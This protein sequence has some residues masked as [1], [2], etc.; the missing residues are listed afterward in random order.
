MRAA[1]L[2]LM[3]LSFWLVA[4][5]AAGTPTVPADDLP[6]EFRRD[7]HILE[8]ERFQWRLA[9]RNEKAAE[10]LASQPDMNVVTEVWHT[11]L[12]K[13][14]HVL[15]IVFA[16]PYKVEGNGINLYIKADNDPGTG[17]RAAGIMEGVDYMF[18]F[19]FRGE[20][21]QARS[22]TH[23]DGEGKAA[24][25]G[26]ADVLRGDTLYLSVDMACQQL[27][28]ASVL[29]FRSSSYT[30]VEVDGKWQVG[31]R[32]GYGPVRFSGAPEPTTTPK[33]PPFTPLVNPELK[34]KGD[35][36]PGWQLK[37]RTSGSEARA[38]WDVEADALRIGRLHPSEALRQRI[39]VAPGHYL[40]RAL[41]RT[42]AFRMHLVAGS[43]KMPV[44]VSAEFRWVELP[45]LVQHVE[46]KGG[47]SLDVGF[48]YMGRTSSAPPAHLPVTLW[49]RRVELRRLGDTVLQRD[50]M[51]N[52]PAHP[53]HH[54]DLIEASPSRS[55]PGKVVFRDSFVGTELWLMTQGGQDDHSYVG[56]PD[57]NRDG[58]F[59]HIGYRRAPSGVLRTD[60]SA[61]YMNNKWHHL[62]WLFPWMERRLPPG[63]N[64]VEWV[65]DSRTDEAVTL[66]N[67]VNGGSCRIELP[68]RPGWRIVHYPGSSSYGARG[69]RIPAVD[70]E[71]MVWLAED[72]RSVAT[73]TAEGDAFRFYPIP[74]ISAAP[75]EDIVHDCIATAL[76]KPGDNWRDAV[77]GQDRRYFFF[78]LNQDNL[79]TH[80]TNPYQV[81]A[82]P[83][84]GKHRGPLRVVS[85]P[86]G[87]VTGIV[88]SVLGGRVK[89]KS[90]MWWDFAAGLPWSGDDARFLLEDGTLVHM[91]SLGG[92]GS[93]AFAGPTTVTLNG[94][95]SEENRFVGTYTRIDR[96]TWPHEYRRDRDFAVVGGL[97][98]PVLPLLMIDL[99]HK[100]MWTATLTNYYDYRSRYGNHLDK[101]SYRKPMF[102]PAPTFSPDFT[103]VSY[104]SSM[105]TGDVPERPLGDVYIA[106]VRYPAPPRSV[107]LGWR[108]T[109][110]WELPQHHAEI[111]GY[112][113]YRSDESGRGY[114]RAA[115]KLLTGTNHRLPADASGFYVLTSVEHSGLEGRVFS[116]EVQL[117]DAPLFRHFHELEHG[118][119]QAPMVPCFDPADASGGYAVALSDPEHVYHEALAQGLR[120]RVALPLRVPERRGLH[121]WA[122]VRGLSELERA[123]YTHGWPC[124][125]KD[126]PAGSMELRCAGQILGSFP[127]RG[128]R[129]HW[130]PLDAGAV[131]L[132]KRKAILEL[133]TSD[134]GVAVDVLC[135]TNDAEFRPTGHGASPVSLPSVPTG[136]EPAVFTL[137]DADIHQLPGASV[138]FTWISTPAPQGV[139]RYQVYR[140]RKPDFPAGA[141]HL[142][143]SPA[144]P[145]FYDCDLEPESTHF[146]RVRAMDAWGNLSGASDALGIRASVSPLRP[147]FRHEP[148]NGG[149]SPSGTSVAFDATESRA[150]GG[151]IN[152]WLW[153][154]GDG[155]V[156]EG[157]K[158]NHTYAE[159]GSHTVTLRI[160]T[161]LGQGAKLT[162]A[163]HVAAARIQRVRAAGGIWIEAEEKT[164][165]GGGKSRTFSG[166]VN[167]SGKI[168]TYWG[169]E[170]GHWLEWTI[171]V[172]KAGVYAIALRYAARAKATRDCRIDGESPG[173]DWN[174][175]V[176]PNTGGYSTTADNWSWRMLKDGNGEPLRHRLSAGKH[177][178]HLTA[179]VAG[180]AVDTIFC[181]PIDCAKELE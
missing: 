48:G 169:G 77:D 172:T 32:L 26:F 4:H 66:V 160:G 156:S 3:P 71:T 65:I 158:V 18:S 68:S 67:A 87:P 85:H 141:E 140:G 104:F 130:V 31:K 83:L 142:I 19:S 61:R 51:K 74:S 91:S 134:R 57:F 170:K 15:K 132:P 88:T 122:R 22:W 72:N 47:K 33:P 147:A 159:P 109:L 6:T 1:F 56:T 116:N 58:S 81:V 135:I 166:R 92:H 120:G 138:K 25:T 86:V 125:D 168:V 153:D 121:V 179:Q 70:H 115:G 29:E 82:V 165:E 129:W 69:P 103:K 36:V 60:G 152:T 43:M 171:P 94:L 154:F 117:G 112:R 75:E 161:D 110:S 7:S 144:E 40:L 123:T 98:E 149:L 11:P 62:V 139:A 8:K 37:V 24:P 167:A 16:Q 146:Y 9:G 173:P 131:L 21:P 44:P 181:I 90:G 148:R 108:R 176:F 175:L 41:A 164:G 126:T 64:P 73:S 124:K 100:T 42:D 97:D 49:A 118:Q 119:I 99:E 12:H 93:F 102:R 38:E 52:L 114:Q 163:I 63:A 111:R 101:G 80:K 113:L 178:L 174:G 34:L 133:T 136:L 127:V 17:R 84:T 13:A 76:F 105:V 55:R 2:L 151:E 14:R 23:W 180:M 28:G 128:A 137:E 27:D 78:D 96:V 155:A 39:T 50:W 95:E 35:T 107:R 145:V 177:I 106:V 46:R 143:G 79:L 162:K 45:F 59:L 20:G 10:Q 5:A 53:R 30:W 89:M 150:S 157:A 54:L